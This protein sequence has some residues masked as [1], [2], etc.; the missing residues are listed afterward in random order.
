[1]AELLCCGPPEEN[2]VPQVPLG[3]TCQICHSAP[4][5]PIVK[6]SR[7][8]SSFWLTTGIEIPPM[9][10]GLPSEAQVLQPPL[11]TTC[12]ICQS[13]LSEPIAKA[14]RRPSSFTCTLKGGL[15]P[16][17]VGLPREFQLL[18]LPL[19]ATCQICQSAKSGPVAKTS[20]RPS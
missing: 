8:P 17:F 14:S 6:A 18:Q 3:A 4:S 5:E 15:I 10:E 7:R 9:P 1:M 16:S 20:R 12:Q 11:G 2:Q 13:A 19:G